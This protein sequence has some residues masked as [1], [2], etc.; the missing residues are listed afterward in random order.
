MTDVGFPLRRLIVIQKIQV[1]EKLN[2]NSNDVGSDFRELKFECVQPKSQLECN[3]SLYYCLHIL[4]LRL[5]YDKLHLC[6]SWLGKIKDFKGMI[7]KK[8]LIIFVM[9]ITRL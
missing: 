1:K 3:S 5:W 7:E 4:K 8:S 2:C 6:L 9:Q